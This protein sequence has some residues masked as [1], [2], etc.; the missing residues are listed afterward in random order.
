MVA[1]AVAAVLVAGGLSLATGT[2]AHAAQSWNH[3]DGFDSSPQSTWGFVGT[4]GFHLN[5]G[6]AFTPPNNAWVSAQ[7]G[8]SSVGK[9]LTL[10]GTGGGPISCDAVIHVRA[11]SGARV[12][13]EIIRPSNWTYIA[14]LPATVSASTSYQPLVLNDWNGSARN[15][16]VR[17]ALI[18]EGTLK[19][20]R[21]DHLFVHCDFTVI[22]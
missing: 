18:G 21:V 22:E 9:P 6:T 5:Q 14:L 4:G 15:V 10:P 17:L 7:T 12:N 11:P 1:A 20:I 13:F 19:T 3:I 2:V 16:F 8:W